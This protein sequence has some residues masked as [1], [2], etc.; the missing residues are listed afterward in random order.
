MLPA[1]PSFWWPRAPL[2]WGCIP[3]VS[4]LARPLRVWASDPPLL[5]CVRTLRGLRA[6]SKFRMASSGILTLSSQVRS[7]SLVLGVRTGTQLLG[8]T[9]HPT[10]E[11]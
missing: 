4:G 7:P 11:L 2:A 8:G 6:P 1:S 9:S 3:V 10:T 5:S